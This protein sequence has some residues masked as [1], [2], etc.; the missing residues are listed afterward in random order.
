[1]FLF[2]R[3]FAKEPFSQAITG[4]SGINRGTVL[5]KAGR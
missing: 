4:K 3:I 5:R 1:L 2:A